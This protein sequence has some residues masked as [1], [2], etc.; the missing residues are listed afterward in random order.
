[1]ETIKDQVAVEATIAE[2]VWTDAF[3]GIPPAASTTLVERL[4][5]NLEVS[6]HCGFAVQSA[7]HNMMPMR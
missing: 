5:V 7:L 3:G 2:Q 1:M 6:S 4:N